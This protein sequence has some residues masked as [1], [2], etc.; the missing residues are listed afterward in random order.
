MPFKLNIPAILACAAI[1]FSSASQAGV[2]EEQ[3]AQHTS[4]AKAASTAFAGFSVERDR[5]LHT[6]NFSG[7]TARC[8]AD[9]DLVLRPQPVGNITA[10]RAG[11][12]FCI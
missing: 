8:Q 11:G 10:R 9:R 4:A 1:A 5:S 6:Q 7:G 3:L 12:G 2:R